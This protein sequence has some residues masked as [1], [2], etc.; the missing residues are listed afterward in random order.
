M[1]KFVKVITVA[2]GLLIGAYCTFAATP[3]QT[4]VFLNYYDQLTNYQGKPGNYFVRDAAGTTTGQ[5]GDPTVNKGWAIYIWN[6][7]GQTNGSGKWTK[8][9]EE[10]QLD[11]TVNEML[12]AQ[13]ATKSHVQQM[14][15]SVYTELYKKA[16][17]TET[18]RLNTL[19]GTLDRRVENAENS[20]AV[21]QNDISRVETKTDAAAQAVSSIREQ[22]RDITGEGLS[23]ISNKVEQLVTSVNTLNTHL[24]TIE[25]LLSRMNLG[26]DDAYTINHLR[27]ALKDLKDAIGPKPDPDPSGN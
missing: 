24:N 4:Y 19:I 13:Y 14:I 5:H 11:A 17:S 6:T 3:T 27:S 20:V 25:Q 22:I 23:D 8:V 9:A 15:D 1:P 2:F 12:L 16:D 10:E 7:Q 26:D 21:V 18:A